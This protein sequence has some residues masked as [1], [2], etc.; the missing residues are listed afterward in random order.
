MWL[1]TKIRKVKFSKEEYQ[2]KITQFLESKSS[3]T[4]YN[5]Y[6]RQEKET[7]LEWTYICEYFLNNFGFYQPNAQN[8]KFEQPEPH[9]LFTIE[10]DKEQAL[11][12]YRQKFELGPYL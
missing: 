1:K 10:Y 12:T 6:N 2:D 7:E 8:L 4:K 5:Y 11:K 3:I 9:Q